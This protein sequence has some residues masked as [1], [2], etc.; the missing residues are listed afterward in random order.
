MPSMMW[1]ALQGSS[2]MWLKQVN[3]ASIVEKHAGHFEALHHFP[4]SIFIGGHCICG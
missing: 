2:D 3:D 1:K 4:N